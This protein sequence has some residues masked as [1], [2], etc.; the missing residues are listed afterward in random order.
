MGI[1]AEL[2]LDPV[3]LLEKR[4]WL[5]MVAKGTQRPEK[6][7]S[8]YILVYDFFFFVK[9]RMFVAKLKEQYGVLVVSIQ[10]YR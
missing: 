5:N 3:F 2:V 1:K 4:E 9:I 10:Y 8:R 6:I 7:K